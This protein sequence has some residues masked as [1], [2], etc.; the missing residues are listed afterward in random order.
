[1]YWFSN[2]D[3]SLAAWYC[4]GNIYETSNGYN[5]L[6]NEKYLVLLLMILSIFHSQA[7][8]TQGITEL[9]FYCFMS[10]T[11]FFRDYSQSMCFFIYHF[12]IYIYLWSGHSQYIH[13]LQDYLTHR[14]RDKM[15][16]I[17]QTTFSTAISWMKMFEFRLKF[18]WSLFPR[19]QL[20]IFQHWF[21]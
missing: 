20:T 16:T 4:Q 6:R 1:M 2:K 21:R 13:I 3:N 11:V 8:Y 12:Y 10:Y 17:S 19:I 7:E 15:D 18:H 5:L 9:R 14:G